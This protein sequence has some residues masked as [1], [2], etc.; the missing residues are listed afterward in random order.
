MEVNNQ[1]SLK[2]LNQIYNN[3]ENYSIIED[4]SFQTN[5]ENILNTNLKLNNLNLVG[6][7]PYYTLYNIFKT[8]EKI[9]NL[10]EDSI[11]GIIGEAGT[12][13]SN[14]SFI[15]SY[16]L[17]SSFNENRI[18]FNFDELLSFL[19]ECSQ[20]I[21]KEQRDKSYKSYLRAVVVV[22]DEGVYM[23]FSADGNS[24]NGK[25]ATKLFSVIR[26]LNIV[27]FI[28]MTNFEKI[29]KTIRESRLYSTIRIM[30]KGVIEY[31]SK[32]K[33]RN[34]ELDSDNNIIWSEPNF[35]EKVGFLSKDSEFW[36]KYNNK[37]GSFVVN[38]INEILIEYEKC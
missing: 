12:G 11:I 23:L 36:K 25:L 3:Y 29:N 10:D 19:K 34:L 13:K 33:T 32:K 22:L 26:F 6:D 24:K 7:I 8:K 20:E 9:L 17:D 1:N 16:F 15:F 14:I 27:M 30:K 2:I 37:K 21:L 5:I 28:N 18:I 31:R 35:I 4:L 38:A